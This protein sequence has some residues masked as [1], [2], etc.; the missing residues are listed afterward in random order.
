M[1]F[2]SFGAGGGF[3]GVCGKRPCIPVRGAGPSFY[4]L[5]QAVQ[6]GN[7]P[8]HTIGFGHIQLATVFLNALGHIL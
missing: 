1:Y 4:R 8:K 7:Y 5:L 6:M 2:N 3:N